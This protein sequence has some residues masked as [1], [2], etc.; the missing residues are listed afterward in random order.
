MNFKLSK[1]IKATTNAFDG[2]TNKVD[3]ILS[4][5]NHELVAMTVPTI[6]KWIQTHHLT[7][8][9]IAWSF[10]VL[11]GSLLSQ[12]SLYFLLLN[13]IAIALHIATDACDGALGRYRKTGL[14]RWGY[15][16]DHF[17]DF[18]FGSLI[19]VSFRII[20][21]D[22]NEYW[23]FFLMMVFSGF[24][25]HSLLSTSVLNKLAYTFFKILSPLEGQ[26]FY[27]AIYFVI[28]F[29]GK[30]SLLFLVPAMGFIGVIALSYIVGDTLNRLWKMD[31]PKFPK[32]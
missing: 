28:I 17:G 1:K 29:F 7:S 9:T 30:I 23:I 2:E 11:A 14:V 19:V 22:V 25:V 3:S 26:L 4:P 24:F 32:D 18:I 12:Y 10:L 15:Y 20:N 27:I 13:I 5:I 8:S 21:H 31:K 6:P 16:A